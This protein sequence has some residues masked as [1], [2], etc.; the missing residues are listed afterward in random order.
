MA[1]FDPASVVEQLSRLG[2][3]L[4]CTVLPDG[5]LAFAPWHGAGGAE[6][7]AALMEAC[8]SS[9]QRVALLNH[10]RAV[11]RVVKG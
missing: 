5:A 9:A 4:H 1:A 8:Q 6:A 11:G 3:E 7:Q 2:L 10:L